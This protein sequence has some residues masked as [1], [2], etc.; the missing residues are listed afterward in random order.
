MQASQALHY[1]K[2]SSIIIMDE[3]GRGTLDD[4]GLILLTS[5]L[6]NFLNQRDSC[7]HIL[8]S[9]HMQ[10]ISNWLPENRY[11]EYFKMDHTFKNGVLCFLH[12]ISK[13]LNINATRHK[14]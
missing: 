3:F 1:W 10:R 8:V 2:P 5:F 12:K 4:D 6:K 7:P 11:L 9:T 14:F 13:G